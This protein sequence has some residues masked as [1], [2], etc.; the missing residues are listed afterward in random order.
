MHNAAFIARI[1]VRQQLQ[2][3]TVY[4][5]SRQTRWQKEQATTENEQATTEN[6]QAT[7]DFVRITI[8]ASPGFVTTTTS[9]LADSIAFTISERDRCDN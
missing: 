3:Q 7:T 4:G 9:S 1:Q 5:C 2:L 6:E 8:T